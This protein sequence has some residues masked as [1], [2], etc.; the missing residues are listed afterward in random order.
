[1][2]ERLGHKLN[3]TYNQAGTPCRYTSHCMD[4]QL[5]ILERLGDKV[6]TTVHINHRGWDFVGKHQVYS[7]CALSRLDH[8]VHIRERPRNQVYISYMYGAGYRYGTHR[9][10]M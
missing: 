4:A 8:Q 2:L 9:E 3:M 1:M 6:H 5:H 7:M 10:G